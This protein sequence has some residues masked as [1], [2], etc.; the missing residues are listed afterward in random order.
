MEKIAATPPPLPA[1]GQASALLFERKARIQN[2]IEL[3]KCRFGIGGRLKQI[4]PLSPDEFE[5]K[6][7]EMLK[8]LTFLNNR[9]AQK[10]G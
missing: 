6:R 5:Q 3:F 4:K 2:E 1:G 8:A 7:R 10:S 9:A